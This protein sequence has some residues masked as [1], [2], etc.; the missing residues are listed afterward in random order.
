VKSDEDRK[1]LELFY[2]QQTVARPVLSP[3]AVPADRLAVLRT[4]FMAMANDDAFH[5]DAAKAKLEV[6]PSSYAE[7]E[8]VVHHISTTPP[9]IVER[10]AKVV[11]PPG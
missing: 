7:I 4:A 1:G 3:P 5:K 11:T 2:L 9:E 6:A 10:L 8:K